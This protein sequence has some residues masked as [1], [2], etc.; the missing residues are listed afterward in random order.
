MM[1]VVGVIC[2]YNPFHLGHGKQFWLI[3]EQFGPDTAVVCMMS[4]N[5]VQRGEPAVFDKFARS[6]AALL[7]GADLVLELPVTC[8]LSSAE[9]F[10]MGG[11]AGLTR[12]GVVDA[13]CFGSEHGDA[14]ALRETA[15][16][17]NS[18]ELSSALRARL[19]D[20]TSFAAARAEAVRDLG[21]DD[22][23]L[24]R[25]NDILAV[26][27]CK[28]LERLDSPLVPVVVRRDGDYH[29][30]SPSD[31]DPSATALRRLL[32]DGGDWARYVPPEAAQVFAGA[33]QYAMEYGERAMLARLRTLPDE[34][35]RTMPY[36]A[37]GLWNKV[38]RACRTEPTVAAILEASK[39]KRY[40]YSRLKRMV[41]CAYLG[42][43]AADLQKT[44]P[45]I[46]VLAFNDA[47]RALLRR[48]KTNGGIELVNAGQ[49]PPEPAYAALERRAASLYALFARDTA[50]TMCG[51][52]ENGRVFYDGNQ[53]KHLQNEIEC[54][55]IPKHDKT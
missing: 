7:A 18:P 19:K 33:T 37:E 8:A 36:G 20:G 31:T 51:M 6:R 43:T 27:Y 45:Y 32:A 55:I 10:A 3:R 22:A 44:P 29:A 46:R 24:R 23:L 50:A 17:L 52:E 11:V 2:E 15:R 48:A 40:A 49:T 9:G 21:G 14:A 39:S 25:P 41:M 42:I 12:L 34:A 53:K 16:L 54:D 13:L 47:G 30:G 28:A 26:E 4:G 1:K 38:R 35:F 5:F